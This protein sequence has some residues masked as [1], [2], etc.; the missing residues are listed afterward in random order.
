MIVRIDMFYYYSTAPGLQR[1]GI[2]V[3]AWAAVC[4]ATDANMADL[5]IS[6]VES[7]GWSWRDIDGENCLCADLVLKSNGKII[8]RIEQHD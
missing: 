2:G 1:V 6:T 5:I 8:G 4:D 3:T 7:L